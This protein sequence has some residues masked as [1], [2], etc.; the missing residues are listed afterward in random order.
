MKAIRKSDGKE[1]E[2]EIQHPL[3]Y[4]SRN[5]KGIPDRVYSPEALVI[6]EIIDWQSFRREA[7][8]EIL[9]GMMS[10]EA[11]LYGGKHTGIQVHLAIEY[12]DE[13]I[14]QLNEE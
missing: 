8:K 7:A 12:A 10:H 4:F 9:A 5:E 13:L 1:I 11:V 3:L 2:V 14:K 6:P